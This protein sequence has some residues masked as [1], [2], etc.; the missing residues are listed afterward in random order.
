MRKLWQSVLWICFIMFILGCA[1][2]AAGLLSGA[3]VDTLKAHGGFDR[4]LAWLSRAAVP[5]RQELRTLWE[6]IF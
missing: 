5:V 3:G 1:L 4:Y 2:V 6:T